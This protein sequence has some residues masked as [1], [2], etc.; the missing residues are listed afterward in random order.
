MLAVLAPLLCS[1]H[2]TGS[3]IMRVIPDVRALKGIVPVAMLVAVGAC[4]TDNAKRIDAPAQVQQAAP[5][6]NNEPTFTSAASVSV[7]EGTAMTGY[8]ATATDAD[9]DA[10]TYSISGGAD[11]AAFTIDGAT[12][13]LSFAM[14]PDFAAPGD[15]NA[16]NVY[17][18]QLQA[19]DGTDSDLLDLMV[20]VTSTNVAPV[21]TSSGSVTV[22]EG[23]TSTG[24]TASA[25]DADGDVLTFSI[26]GGTDAASFS[27][28]GSAGSLS[29]G[30]PPDFAA[31]GDADADNVY[32]VSLEVSDGAETD[33]LDLSVTV[34]A[35]GGLGVQVAFPTPNANLGGIDTT[36]VTGRIVDL[37]GAPVNPADIDFVEVG[38]VVAT[39]AVDD[40]TR[41]SAQVPVVPGDNLVAVVFH[42]SDGVQIA[43]DLPLQ[44]SVL[45]PGFND[46]EIDTS[47]VAAD[48]ALAIDSFIDGLLAVDLTTGV[49][50]AVSDGTVGAGTNFSSPRD[51]AIDT[52]AGRGLVVDWQRDALV[53]VD[54]TTGDR[55]DIASPTVGA[56]VA[57]D[58]PIS[59]A[60]DAANDRAL[61]VHSANADVIAVDL[62]T[63]DR[64]VLSG[65]AVGAGPALDD[66][67]DIEVDNVSAV[68]SRR[69]YVSDT[70][71]DA[72]V[73]IDLT[74]GDRTILSDAANGAGPTVSPESLS[75]D[76]GND[77]I[78]AAN[79]GGEVIAVDMT[80]GDRTLLTDL[81]VDYGPNGTRLLGVAVDGARALVADNRVD[82]IFAIDLTTTDRT[83]LSD[84]S[85]GA[86]P[87]RAGLWVLDG[88]ALD[89]TGNRLVVANREA[90]AV[91]G[92]DLASGDRSIVSSDG[93]TVPAMGTG[94]I[95]ATP[96]KLTVDEASNQA[97]VIPGPGSVYAI[98]LA[99]GDRTVVSANGAVGAGEDF[100]AP[101]DIA[102]DVPGNRA[103]VMDT[104]KGVL[105]VDLPTGDRTVL[106]GGAVGA[107]PAFSQAVS[108]EADFAADT[109]YTLD[110]LDDVL[111]AVDLTT[112]NRTVV[113]SNAG[114]G[115]GPTFNLPDDM[116]LDADNGRIIVIDRGITSLLEV[117]LANGDR[118]VLSS[119]AL[120]TGVSFQSPDLVVLDLDDN[121]A[122]VYDL[123]VTGILVVELS[124]GQRAL[125]SK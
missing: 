120:G 95:I 20:T 111:L 37:A 75:L 81:A 99:T 73:A 11:Q 110:W 74:N 122:F 3:D 76:V 48:R 12:G 97:F 23:N 64:T 92:V 59:V 54:L 115:A 50:S 22:V 90:D 107:G 28:D 4:D 16:D 118:T 91:L 72:I 94:P 34:V 43:S 35:S 101:V 29:F 45:H 80:T 40:P 52:N 18:V 70:N 58:G 69:A 38:G 61:V 53:A 47:G 102:A 67:R 117:S 119:A 77:R 56:G 109:A 5:P 108:L 36:I 114:V 103:L 6:A 15:A 85:V 44:N 1:K 42:R 84:D 13:S 79:L 27:I 121:R 116:A 96:Q 125:M 51:V 62:A 88:M 123:A 19:S 65:A 106:S 98:D 31:P 105:N 60:Y 17:E 8:T 68:A 41:W 39:F 24:Y 82:A 32:E 55:T 9:N 100:A 33:T 83:V 26:A 71:L 66:P 14:A 124:T 2:E 63:G 25:T 86:G 49:R 113:S 89:R 46:I 93:A 30:A 21:F 104:S 57:L 10:L 7:A 112:G 78:I 87:D